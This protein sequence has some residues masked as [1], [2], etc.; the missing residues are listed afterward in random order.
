IFIEKTVLKKFTIIIIINAIA[1]DIIIVVKEV[2]LPSPVSINNCV[3]IGIDSVKPI[4]KIL[5]KAI[6]R[7]RPTILDG[8]IYLFFQRDG[9]LTF[10]FLKSIPGLATSTYSS[11]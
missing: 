7:Y 11:K 1:R 10:R 9:I 8:Q 2:T 4:N 3:N 6:L 5:I